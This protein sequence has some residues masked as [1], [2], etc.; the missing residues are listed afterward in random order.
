MPEETRARVIR[1]SA[2]NIR[3]FLKGEKLNVVN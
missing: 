2:D 3:A 1:I